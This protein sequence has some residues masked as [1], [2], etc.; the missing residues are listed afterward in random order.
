MKVV[1]WGVCVFEKK[2]GGYR[3]GKEGE[4]A[5]FLDFALMGIE[6]ATLRDLG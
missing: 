1:G 3:L 6:F 4:F 5:K 2:C